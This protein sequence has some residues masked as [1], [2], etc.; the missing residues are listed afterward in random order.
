MAALI[1]FLSVM[2]LLPQAVQACEA[3]A[4]DAAK[5]RELIGD[6][7]VTF[8]VSAGC[9]DAAELNPAMARRQFSPNSTFKIPN[10]VIA[11]DSGIASG[12]DFAIRYDADR[13]P[14]QDWW[15]KDW[16]Q[17]QTL[18]T[19]FKRSAVWYYQEL[20]RRIGANRYREA[21]AKFQYGNKDISGGVDQFWL[22]ST[23]K[24]SPIE[25]IAFLS[26]L[27]NGD[28]NVS[29]A[30]LSVLNEISLIEEADGHA[31]HGKTGAGPLDRASTDDPLLAFKGRFG[32][33]LVGWVHRP[34]KK[35]AYY[36]L[37]AEGPT[38][39]SIAKFRQEIARRLLV[40]EGYLPPSFAPPAT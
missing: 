13:N 7:Q 14:K 37:Y 21:L 39:A 23:L 15:P 26:A 17:D 12:P 29:N 36:A 35:P 19:A 22:S 6:R 16:A 33:W 4:I 18:A 8:V 2:C 10:S 28:F 34:N 3:R 9:G 40:D 1:I 38:F 31:L 11:L 5:Y 32:G 20:A 25:Q 24:I 27:F 30:S